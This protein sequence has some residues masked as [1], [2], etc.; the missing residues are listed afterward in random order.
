MSVDANQVK[1]CVE[2]IW[3][4]SKNFSK[5]SRLH[6][7]NSSCH[8][9]ATCEQ[10]VNYEQTKRN[11]WVTRL[12]NAC[13]DV[14]ILK[15]SPRPGTHYP[16]SHTSPRTLARYLPSLARWI[17]C[18]GVNRLSC[19]CETCFIPTVRGQNSQRHVYLTVCCV[20]LSCL[21]DEQLG[22][23]KGVT[24]LA[25]AAITNALWD[26][27]ARINNKVTTFSTL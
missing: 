12:S 7:T 3:T 26:L 11:Y 15:F 25:V 6:T 8:I 27:W 2:R 21:S 20:E 22:P 9:R 5:V 18:H 1:S 14:N 24:H 13:R 4:C 17:A 16:H 23:E 19:Q 10:V